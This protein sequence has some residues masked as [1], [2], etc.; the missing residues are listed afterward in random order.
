MIDTSMRAASASSLSASVGVGLVVAVPAAVVAGGVAAGACVVAVALGSGL[1]AGPSGGVAV[2]ACVV[3]VAFGSSL[4]AGPLVAAAGA[5]SVDAGIVAVVGVVALGGAPALA[6]GRLGCPWGLCG[7]VGA[8]DT[9][10]ALV[11]VGGVAERSVGS[12]VAVLG[13]GPKR[14]RSASACVR[15]LRSAVVCVCAFGLC[16]C[17]CAC[18]RVC[19]R[20]CVHPGMCVRAWLR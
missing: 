4:W 18:V 5:G 16:A 6:H 9:H 14:G 7:C 20:V 11:V 3:A 17:V 10:P 15:M 8:V 1:W 13:C 19:V 2:G 12:T